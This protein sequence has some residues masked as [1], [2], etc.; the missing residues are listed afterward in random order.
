[1]QARECHFRLP[2]GRKCRAAATRNQP[3]CRHH[4]PKPAVAGPPPL[5]KRDL[6]CRLGHWAHV[7]RNIPWFDPAEIPDE[8]YGILYSL[9][10]DDVGGI[11]DR[12]AGR[13]LRGLLR[14]V[15]QVPFPLPG[16]SGADARSASFPMPMPARQPADADPLADPA[17][18]NRMMAALG[19]ANPRG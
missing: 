14:R 3:F 2:N 12:E 15:G 10:Q 5:R 6:Y 9:L 19:I 4:R 16:S 7:S 13:L 17:A 18:L 11:S 8:I 1:M